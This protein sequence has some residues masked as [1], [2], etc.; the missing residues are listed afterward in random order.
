MKC[1]KQTVS[2][3]MDVISGPEVSIP[4]THCKN[5]SS[6]SLHLQSSDLSAVRQP[7]VSSRTPLLSGFF[8]GVLSP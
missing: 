2:C 6:S 8:A 5:S 7:R 1:V 3:V 4:L